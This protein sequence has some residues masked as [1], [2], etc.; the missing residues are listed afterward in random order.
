MM[1]PMRFLRDCVTFYSGGTPSK[2]NPEYWGGEIPWVSSGEMG[3]Q[4]I[5]N[6]SLKLTELG[7]IAGSRLVSQGTIFAVVRGM[8]LA[9]EF[10]VSYAMKRMAFN[11][12]V[13]AM[14][15]K[16]GIDSYFLF[17]SLRAH[18][19]EIRN[20]ATEAAHGTKKL[21]M[22]RLESFQIPIPP[23]Y[24]QKKVAAIVSAY[25]DLIETNRRR[26]AL[27]EESARLFYRE[28]FVEMRFPGA[29]VHKNQTN[30]PNGWQRGRLDEALVL[31]RGFDL[32]NDSRKDGIVPV[33]S[34]MGVHGFHSEAKVAGPGVVTGRSGTLGIVH[35]VHGD[36]WPLNT[37]LWVKEF[38][39]VTPLFACFMLRELNLAQFNSGASV[40]SLD[41]KVVHPI[42]VVIPEMTA[43]QRF[44]EVTG[45]MFLQ[46][47]SLEDMNNK[48]A[49]A[50]DE[51][52][53]RLM[54]GQIKV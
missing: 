15:A 36:F 27:L 44:D 11:Q 42:E 5:S 40:P 38:K 23:F 54:S 8:S 52:L 35:Y 24:M 21:E 50:R 39:K 34:S 22:E 12:D 4:F 2:G 29:N 51:L 9:K 13:K 25:D 30:L 16:E 53:P 18:S 49:Q 3:V 10:R 26:I 17:A 28:W 45:P 31:Q 1:W 41:R 43:I 47:K 33:Y 20:L 14:I 32:P 48:A 37:A 6:T 19:N 46:I 7:A